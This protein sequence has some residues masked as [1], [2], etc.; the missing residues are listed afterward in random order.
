MAKVTYDSKAAPDLP[1]DT[2]HFGYDFVGSKP[3]D[4]ENP[5]HLKKFAGHPFFKVH[6]NVPDTPVVRSAAERESAALGTGSAETITRVEKPLPAVA[7]VQPQP[8]KAPVT[9]GQADKK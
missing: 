9:P 6:G 2:T 4:V 8:D 7:V 5:A 3:V 1:D